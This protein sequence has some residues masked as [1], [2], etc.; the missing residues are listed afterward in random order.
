MS[1]DLDINQPINQQ[2]C[3]LFLHRIQYR[4][5]NGWESDFWCSFPLAARLHSQ[6]QWNQEAC[7]ANSGWH[8]NQCAPCGT[9]SSIWPSLRCG[10]RERM[11]R[12]GGGED[13]T[14]PRWE[15]KLLICL[16][17]RKKYMHAL[18][19]CKCVY[20]LTFLSGSH[21]IQMSTDERV[22]KT[23]L[24]NWKQRLQLNLATLIR[25]VFTNTCFWSFC[26]F[27]L[28][29]KTHILIRNVSLE[30]GVSTILLCAATLST[31]VYKKPAG[32]L[33]LLLWQ[34]M[35]MRRR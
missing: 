19:E 26:R 7:A 25:I 1:W 13:L 32:I 17:K 5:S 28:P 6:R 24:I 2:N 23:S 31:T 35:Q 11:G 27:N 29:L 30:T 14:A 21:Q 18:N 4:C 34:A 16:K 33:T 22:C 15:K 20:W 10:C 8:L 12:R 3:F 9:H